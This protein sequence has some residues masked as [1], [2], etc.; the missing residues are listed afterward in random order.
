M[1]GCVALIIPHDRTVGLV[2]VGDDSAI[3]ADEPPVV[4]CF[5]EVGR[6]CDLWA[7]KMREWVEG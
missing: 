1:N 5:V 2:H 3:P 7:R 6:C 4:I